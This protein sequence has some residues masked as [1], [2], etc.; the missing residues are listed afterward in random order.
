M[1]WKWAYYGDIP[2]NAVPCA[3]TAMSKGNCYLGVSMYSDGICQESTGKII[4]AHG[5]RAPKMTFLPI[6]GVKNPE[7]QKFFFLQFS[8]FLGPIDGTND[9]FCSG[10]PFWLYSE[11]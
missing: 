7:I 6:L 9:I 5:V 4:T 10:L 11:S 1:G 2:E 8:I 3:D